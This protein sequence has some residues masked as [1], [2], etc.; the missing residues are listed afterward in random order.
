MSLLKDIFLL[1]FNI[2]KKMTENTSKVILI[3]SLECEE[4]TKKEEEK[5]S[6]SKE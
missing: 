4:E 1:P 6:E 2:A 5:E 3:R